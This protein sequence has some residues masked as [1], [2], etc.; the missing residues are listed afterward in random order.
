M[1]Y[2]L[3]IF[4]DQVIV[5][6]ALSQCGIMWTGK[7]GDSYIHGTCSSSDLLTVSLLP[8]SAVCRNCKKQGGEYVW[9]QKGG[10]GQMNKKSIAEGGGM[11]LLEPGRDLNQGELKGVEWLRSLYSE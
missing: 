9:H 5:N 10:R 7:N 1:Q 6:K 2:Q 4:D 8:A 3:G 11:W